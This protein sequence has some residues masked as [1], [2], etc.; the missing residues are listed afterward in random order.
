LTAN[1]LRSELEKCTQAGMNTVLTKPFLEE[2][3]LRAMIAHAPAKT[4]AP[5]TAS[6]CDLTK[7]QAIAKG[8]EAFVKQMVRLFAEQGPA[9][10]KEMRSAFAAGDASRVGDLAHRLKSSLDT[11]G[12]ARIHGAVRELEAL[13]KTG[14]TSPRM[15]E[16]LMELEQVVSLAVA[17][18]T[19]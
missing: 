14:R 6:L 12:I 15:E 13:G 3:L 18:L 1:A 11:L 19:A 16:L 7:L 9:T 17:E 8:D 2:D 4:P 10:I 5:A